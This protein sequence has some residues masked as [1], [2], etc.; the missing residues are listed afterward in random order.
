[1]RGKAFLLS[2]AIISFLSSITL[3]IS[4]GLFIEPLYKRDALAVLVISFS[5][6]L[7]ISIIYTIIRS[8]F[9][10]NKPLNL[11]IQGMICVLI[12]MAFLILIIVPI[13]GFSVKEFLWHLMGVTSFCLIIPY[14][15]QRVERLF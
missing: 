8:I 9:F 13:A 5:V 15:Y 10:K 1:M 2:V 3:Y 11:L 14:T 6:V 12:D 4:Q 7:I